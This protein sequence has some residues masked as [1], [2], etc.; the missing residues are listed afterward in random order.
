MASSPIAKG[1]WLE[2]GAREADYCE[3]C[4][5]NSLR[6]GLLGGEDALSGD[7]CRSGGAAADDL[8]G[9]GD[10]GYARDSLDGEAT[11]SGDAARDGDI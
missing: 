11:R 8:V 7:D 1:D 5:R 3:R 10:R 9:D 6:G 4:C 2:P